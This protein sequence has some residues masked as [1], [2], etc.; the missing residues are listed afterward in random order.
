[1]TLARLLLGGSGSFTPPPPPAVSP[2]V[3]NP[4]P[5][6][7]INPW[8][9]PAAYSYGGVTIFPWIDRVG[10]VEVG[11]F[12]E[13]SKTVTGRYTIHA[14]FQSDAHSSPSLWRRTSDGRIITAY[15]LHNASTFNIRVSTNPDDPSSWGSATGLDAQLGGTRYSDSQLY[16]VDGTLY[17]F[18]RDEPTAGTDSRWCISTTSAATPTSGWAAQTIVYHITGTRSYVT[19]ALDTTSGHIH[20]VATNGGATVGGISGF[21]RLGHFYLDTSDG[22]Y[23]KTDGTTITL[24]LDFSEITEAYAGT[25]GVFMSNVV[26]DAGGHPVVAAQDRIAGALRYIYVRASGSSWAA[27]NVAAV[28]T[29]YEYSGTGTGFGAWGS[30]IRDSDPDRMYAIRDT[31]SLPEVYRY[32]TGDGGATFSETQETTGATYPY[33]T[34]VCVRNDSEALQAMCEQGIWGSYKNYNVGLVGFGV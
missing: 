1:M 6:G 9:T 32:D 12:D 20:F 21:S 30:C 11:V 10:N 34:M 28:G 23:H 16:E 18:Y 2:Y 31:G 33:F 3:L 5:D 25:T 26:I 7:A 14:A 13:A 19:S 15:S 22:T 4:A 29:G 8:Q 27:T 24:P 17:L